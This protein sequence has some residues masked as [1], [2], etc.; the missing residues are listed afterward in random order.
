M[1]TS[2]TQPASDQLIQCTQATPSWVNITT[3]TPRQ[4]TA[5]GDP[6][7]LRDHTLL[8]T[9]PTYEN[10]RRVLK[11]ASDDLA[12]SDI[13]GTKDGVEALI[14]IPLTTNAFKKKQLLLTP[15]QVPPV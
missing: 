12:T 3:N 5:R 7:Q 10:Q 1:N 6:I 9:C 8:T 11:D 14:E 13:L 15:P 2:P 4:K